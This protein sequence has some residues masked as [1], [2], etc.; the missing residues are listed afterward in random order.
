MCHAG[1]AFTVT[2]PTSSD[3]SKSYW[4]ECSAC[5]AHY[6]VEYVAGLNEKPKCHFCRF[7][8]LNLNAPMVQCVS[9]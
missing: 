5:T 4:C 9:C 3:P 2:D 6:A 8:N 1:V 7:E